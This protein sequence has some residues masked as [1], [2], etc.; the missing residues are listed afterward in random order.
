MHVNIKHKA[1]VFSTL[2]SDPEVLRELYSAIQG[3]DVPPEAVININTLTGILY[4]GKLNDVSFTI[5]DQIIVLIEHQSTINNNIPVRMLM[6]VARIYEKILDR[7]KLYQKKLINIPTPEFYILYNGSEPFEE[8]KELRLSSSFKNINELGQYKS[9]IYP[10]ELTVQVYNI[11]QGKNTEILNKSEILNCYSKFIGKIREY[12]KYLSLEESIEA[13][14][15]YCIENNILKS[16]L[17]EHGPEVINMLTDDIS[18]EEIA[19]IRYKEG[20]ED[21]MEEGFNYVL[22][23]LSQGISSDEIKKLLTQKN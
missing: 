15:K 12:N 4:M 18:V 5:N 7:E 10:L 20:H 1:S 23:L 8:Y 22:E 2:F 16:F 21:G 3:I 19:A 6:Y 9:G 14:I 11:N 13:A 17:R